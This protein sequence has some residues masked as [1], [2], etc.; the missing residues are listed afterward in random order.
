MFLTGISW[1]QILDPS[2]TLCAPLCWLVAAWPGLGPYKRH[3]VAL[4]RGERGGSGGNGRVNGPTT[5]QS[6]V[7]KQCR[8]E[9]ARTIELHG[10]GGVGCAGVGEGA[11]VCTTCGRS[12]AC[13]TT[14][15][16]RHY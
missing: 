9:G 11:M 5:W 10:M 8:E 6:Q 14:T 1:V 3:G 16:G 12:T 7:G 13:A 15:A 2:L 4:A